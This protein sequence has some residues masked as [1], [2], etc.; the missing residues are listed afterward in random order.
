MTNSAAPSVIVE[1]VDGIAVIALCRPPV[2]ALGLD[3]RRA[4]HSALGSADSNNAVRAV[5]LSSA[6]SGFSAGGDRREIQTG[7]VMGW[8][9]LTL[10]IY[11]MIE[12]MTKPVVAAAHG[13]S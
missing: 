5:I 7:E 6:R 3:L 8:P 1:V 2:N 12:Q 13:Y 4:L 10:D 11:P 9:L